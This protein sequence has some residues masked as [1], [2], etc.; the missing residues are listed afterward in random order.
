MVRKS[1]TTPKSSTKA[2]S[3]AKAVIV[4]KPK[5]NEPAAKKVVTAVVSGVVSGAGKRKRSQPT[6][7]ELE[8]RLAHDRRQARKIKKEQERSAK[9]R[10]C[11]RNGIRRMI[12]EA[13]LKDA[14]D[15]QIDETE[16]LQ[17]PRVTKMA[18]EMIHEVLEEEAVS[19]F[20]QASFLL[21]YAGRTTCSPATLCALDRAKMAFDKRPVFDLP[22]TEPTPAQQEAVDAAQEDEE[23][24]AAFTD[25]GSGTE[26]EGET[27]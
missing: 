27:E 17:V 23:E 8:R 2:I 9:K 7:R 19:R 22:E 20:N 24:E 5:V 10:A 25:S 1:L 16:P 11:S 18:V 21:E 12:K 14:K 26:D 15:R 13:L 3:R 6:K 4:R